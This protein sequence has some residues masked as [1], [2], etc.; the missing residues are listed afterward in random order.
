MFLK[1]NIL[2]ARIIQV[3]KNV[4]CF[5]QYQARYVFSDFPEKK[6]IKQTSLSG[7]DITHIT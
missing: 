3:T 1:T 5:P 4:P 6:T 2:N 7:V